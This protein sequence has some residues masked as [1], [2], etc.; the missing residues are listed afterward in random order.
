MAK[1]HNALAQALLKLAPKARSTFDLATELGVGNEELLEFLANVKLPDGIQLVTWNSHLGGQFHE[2]IHPEKPRPEPLPRAFRFMKHKDESYLRVFIPDDIKDEN[3]KPA[4]YIELFPF[5]DVHWGH[6]RCDRKNF[7]LDVKEVARRP[8]RFAFMNGDNM[9]NALGDSAG[10]AAWAEQSSTPKEQ[11]DQLEEVFRP[12]AHKMFCSHPGNH[13]ARTTKKSLMDPLEEVCKSLDIPYFPGPINLEVIWKGY[14]WTFYLFHGTGASNT[15]GGKLT[16]A[17][18]PRGF[19]DFRNFFV[20]GH[21]HDESTHK[22]T[23]MI[24]R[25]EFNG[26]LKRFW[27]EKLKEYKIVCPSYLL[28]TGTYAEEAG[29]SPG[30]RNLVTMQLFANGDYHVLS[31]KRLAEDEKAPARTV[32]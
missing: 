14:R 9:E 29:Y 26:K 7:I 22:V 24:S 18:R 1:D 23:R 8:N 3:G 31:S 13:E 28:Y 30:S 6:K 15:P 17:G 16:A 12:I 27:I 19:N 10:G 25:R 4:K 32:I 21:V 11:R 2:L 5:S 20:M